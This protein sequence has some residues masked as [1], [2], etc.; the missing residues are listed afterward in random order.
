MASGNVGI[1][2]VSPDTTLTVNGGASKVGG[3]SWAT[4][5]DGRLKDVE[6][7][8]T[9]GTDAVMKLN[10]VRYRYKKE[11]GAGIRDRAEHIGLVAQ[12][13]HE[14]IPAAISSSN[15][16][17]LML[18]NDP[19]IWAMLNAVKEQKAANDKLQTVVQEQQAQIDALTKKVGAIEGAR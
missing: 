3:G 10:P 6:G 19:I 13:V 11:N 17:Y 1:G 15:K 8:Y 16:G 12:E 14:A 18:D 4:F 2:T 5:S 9:P 7:A